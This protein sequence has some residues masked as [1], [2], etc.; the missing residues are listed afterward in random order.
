VNWKGNER[1]GRSIFTAII[2]KAAVINDPIQNAGRRGFISRLT[3]EA[4]LNKV[5]LI[6]FLVPLRKL[7]DNTYNYRRKT[8][9]DSHMLSQLTNAHKR[10]KV[11]YTHHTPRK[12]VGH[13]IMVIFGEMYYKGQLHRNIT[14][15]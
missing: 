10:M 5:F 14:G 4:I 9:T 12:R 1:E 8:S 3:R 11:Y 13:S 2:P 15:V 7:Q 6:F